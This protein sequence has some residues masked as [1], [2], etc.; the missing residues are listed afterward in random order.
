MDRFEV[1]LVEPENPVAQDVIAILSR[2]RDRLDARYGGYKLG[3]LSIDGAYLYPLP[4]P[5]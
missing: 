1:K 4:V 3:N 2:F 5:A